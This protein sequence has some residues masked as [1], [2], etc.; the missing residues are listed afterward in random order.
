MNDND[1][2][3]AAVLK[4]LW[5]WLFVG[6]SKMSPLEVVQMLAGLCAIVYT[7]IQI[8]LLVRDRLI[9]RKVTKAAKEGAT[10]DATR[11]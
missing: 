6:I 4:V 11:L 2:T 5:A 1:T 8:Y 9:V 10:H 7:L 3:G